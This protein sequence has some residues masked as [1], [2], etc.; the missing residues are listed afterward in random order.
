MLKFLNSRKFRQGSVATAITA[1]VIALIVVFNMVVSALS[2]RYALSADLTT[3]KIFALSEQTGT[4]LSTLSKDVEIYVLNTEANF[5]AGGDYFVQANEVI[6]K[7]AQQ[8]QRIKLQYIDLVRN[9]TF[10]TQ[11]PN[12]N[13]NTSSI[14]VSSGTKSTDLTPYDLYN[15]ETDQY[16]GS[17]QIV[18]S[19]AEQAMTSAIMRVT[20][21]TLTTVSMLVGHNETELPGLKSLL[22]MN[23]YVILEQNLVTEAVDPAATF[24]VIASPMR[25]F[26]EDELIKL[27]DFLYNGGKLGKTLLYFAAVDQPEMPRLEAFLADWG[28][29]VGVSAVFETSNNRVLSMNMLMP[30]VD[31]TEEV[32]SKS[33]QSSG[34]VTL[35]PY[36][37]PL[38]VLFSEKN[39]ISVSSPLM[40]S[41]TS[42]VI[43]PDAADN[44]QPSEADISGP[45]PALIVAQNLKYDGMEKLTSNVV[46]CGSI[47]AVEDSYLAATSIG[48]GEFFISLFN[49]LSAREDIISIQ[50]KT[51]G[52]GELGIQSQQLITLGLVFVLLLPLAV[53]IFG[54]VVW[55]GRR[56][57]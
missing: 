38:S 57:K 18:S 25:D 20:S 53:F 31:Y 52:G 30:T 27:D 34:L 11:F 29:G 14:V 26:S 50:S 10:T 5:S 17:Q 15:I 39:A 24:A 36:S 3:N 56:H 41:Q 32:Y 8:S 19:K 7:Y 23:N 4:F 33:V 54:I 16:Y 28:I 35:V 44:W 46:A 6:K 42:G 49:E 9:P 43:P 47:L 55:L 2:E 13:L 1:I 40:F 22:E 51:I 45:I 48:N 37:R 12:L 21:D